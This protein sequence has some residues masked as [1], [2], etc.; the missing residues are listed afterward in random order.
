MLAGALALVVLQAH[1]P[2]ADEMTVATDMTSSEVEMAK[3]ET[4]SVAETEGAQS[5]AETLAPAKPLPVPELPQQK[6]S[7]STVEAD[8]A[9]PSPFA[10]DESRWSGQA[11]ATASDTSRALADAIASAGSDGDVVSGNAFAPLMAENPASTSDRITTA[12][13]SPQAEEGAAQVDVAESEADIAALEQ[14]FARREAQGFALVSTGES[15]EPDLGGEER[16]SSMAT[17][18]GTVDRHVNLRAEADNDATILA[19]V[20]QNGQVA[21]LDDCPNWCA[22]EYEGH[23]GYIFGTFIEREDTATDS[24]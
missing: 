21:I 4:A 9:A 17:G 19:V 2:Q 24:L 23:Q 11:P 22:V 13:I 3:S 1:M 6:A 14:A 15:A 16:L 7:A 20:P 18:M 5:I 12:A 8:E 10:I